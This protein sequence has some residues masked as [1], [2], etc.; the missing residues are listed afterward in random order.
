MK[1]KW[2]LKQFAISIDQTINTLFGGWAD[3][4]LSSRAFRMEMEKGITWPRKL[5]DG[6]LFFDP[7]HCQ[8][9]YLSEVERRQ[10][11]PGMR[12]ADDENDAQTA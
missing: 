1:F 2:H 7:D 10:L 9:S 11:P 8:Q 3:E 12:Q 5:I 4:S 6:I